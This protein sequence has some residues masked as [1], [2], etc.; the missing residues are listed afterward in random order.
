MSSTY[1]SSFCL[2]V[3]PSVHP[4]IHSYLPPSTYPG[5]TLSSTE[6]E[7]FLFF[8]LKLEEKLNVL[9][10][11]SKYLAFSHC[12]SQ[13]AS[14]S[15]PLTDIRHHKAVCL[16]THSLQSSGPQLGVTVPPQETFGNV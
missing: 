8:I 7:A 5:N 2:S 3:Y 14:S 1:L 9:L 10:L 6:Y 16:T 13:K 12:V 4:S 11:H 15:G